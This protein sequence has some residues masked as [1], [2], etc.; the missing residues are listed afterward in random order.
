MTEQR[1]WASAARDIA[2]THA[3]AERAEI[4][5]LIVVEG[6]EPHVPGEGPIAITHLGKGHSNETFLLERDGQRCVLRRPPRPPWPPSAHDV[7]REYAFIEGLHPFGL[8]VPAPIAACADPE[9]IGAPFYLM[10]CVEGV[11]VRDTFPP[12]LDEPE[13]RGQAV[14]ALAEGLA[15]LHAVRWQGSP[16]EQLGRP[17]GYLER[18]LR[19]WSGQWE[20]NATR[21]VPQIAQIGEWLAANRPESHDTTVVHGDFKLDNVILHSEPPARLAAIVDWE[22]A[23]LGDPLADLGF[24]CAVY[25]QPGE[26][27]EP[28]LHF[29]AAS[30]APGCPTR[31]EIVQAYG[32]RSGRDVGDLHW[33]EC[34]AIWKIAIIVEGN[35]K[36]Y[37]LGGTNDPFHE[38]VKEGVP[39][40]AERALALTRR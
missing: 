37:L 27:V 26:E 13:T 15:D 18:Q 30:T 11:V 23:T 17:S 8:P 24:T 32:A 16:L 19:R 7:L 25:A 2:E 28:M 29:S 39:R 3:D 14:I 1:E 5:P 38:Q 22:M 35:F 34:L 9:P 31:G 20:H 40:L 4:P 6:L 33:Y 36:R 10:Q 12:E 21:E